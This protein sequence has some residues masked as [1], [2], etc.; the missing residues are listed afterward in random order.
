MFVNQNDY[1]KVL[2]IVYSDEVGFNENVWDNLGLVFL[3]A[4]IFKYT[5]QI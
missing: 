2:S 4:N 3:L 5:F 1:L